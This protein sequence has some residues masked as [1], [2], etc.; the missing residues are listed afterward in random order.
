MCLWLPKG[1]RVRGLLEEFLR[2][3]M[4]KR[5]YE[6]VYSPHLGRVELYETS[7]HFPY[8]RDSQF[9]PLFVNDAGALVDAWI[10]R[11]QET[12]GL[13][14]AQE[15]AFLQSAEVLGCE[16]K[17]TVQSFLQRNESRSCKLGSGGMN[18]TWLNQ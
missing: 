5:G 11:L 7:G 15:T 4:L 17:G 12:D 1:A 13:T 8:Y 3:E 10:R 16:L 14:P 9:P 6:P 18:G 2:K